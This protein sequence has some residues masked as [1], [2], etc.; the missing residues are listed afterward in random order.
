MVSAFQKHHVQVLQENSSRS[1]VLAGLCLGQ[2]QV[3]SFCSPG[4]SI[5]VI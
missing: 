4:D 2:W 3:C 1:R 5:M